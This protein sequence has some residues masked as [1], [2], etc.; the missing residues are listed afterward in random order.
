MKPISI[1]AFVFAASLGW[2][3]P[4]WSQQPADHPISQAIAQSDEAL[5]QRDVNRAVV[6][7][8]QALA[9]H[10][11]DERLLLEQARILVYQKRDREA[12]AQVNSVLAKNPS[13]RE[14]KLT[15]AQIY[16]YR[17]DYRRSD[18]LYR[19]L[20]AAD[21]KDEAA[22][23]GLIH[24]LVL[25]DKRQQARLELQKA[26]QLHPNSLRLQQ[27]NDYLQ[28]S[29]AAAREFSPELMHRVQAGE[30]FFSD[31]AGNHS[32]YSSQGF[33]YDLGRNFSSRFRMDESSLWKTGSQ[34]LTVLSG[35]EE[36]RARPNRYVGARASGGFVRFADSSSEPTYSA[37]LDLY[38]LRGLWLSG[39]YS[40]FP[41]V[42]TF[43]AVQFDLLAGG[44]HGR[45]D[46][47]AHNFSFN[48][49][50]FFSHYTDGNNAER[51]Y[52]ELTRWFGAG[53]F[54]VGGG[55]AFRHIHFDQPLAHGYF[56]P[57]Q[58]WSHLGEAGVRLRAGRFYR[59][60]VLGYFGGEREEPAGYTAAGEVLVRNEFVI[61]RWELD[62]NYSH[63]ALAQATGAFHADMVGAAVGYRF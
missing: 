2:S 28:T 8:S 53:K 35:A 23:V 9:R 15:L 46:Y 12:V 4:T 30:T 39:G 43:D 57:D 14:A 59:G 45:A 41:I 37:D 49:S 58:Y 25:E 36:L 27:Y 42:P 13:S 24:N 1:L 34:T 63:F 17:D 32:L 18:A 47:H 48:G 21:A 11:G 29:G 5:E 60:E 20:L 33:T 7:I 3:V 50:A 51:E 52:G 44:W 19:E 40:R 31:N 6:I 55:Y 62:V 16:G 61:R 10:P 56:S 22:A 38:P 26:L 54:S